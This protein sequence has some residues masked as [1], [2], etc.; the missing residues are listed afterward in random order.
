MAAMEEIMEFKR[1]HELAG[2]QPVEE[3]IPGLLDE[4]LVLLV[5]PEGS[6]KTFMAIHMGVHIA[7]GNKWKGQR[8]E[9]GGV[10]YC[11]AE[12]VSFFPYR[13]TTAIDHI[14]RDA[15]AAPFYVYS[16][17]MNLRTDDKGKLSPDVEKLCDSI[18]ALEGKE[19]FRMKLIVFDTLNRFMP[20]GDENNQEECGGLV[21]GCEYLK[22]QLGATIMLVHHTRKD[23]RAVRGNTVL[24]GAADQI[25]I[26]N[27]PEKKLTDEPVL[28]TTKE[29]GKRKDR[30]PIEQWFQFK[31]T[32]MSRG[33][34][35]WTDEYRDSL[36][37]D[38]HDQVV[39][40]QEFKD[41]GEAGCEYVDT[42]VVEETLVV[43][44]CEDPGPE[45][46]KDKWLVDLLKETGP[47][48]VSII[49]RKSGKSQKTCYAAL[50]RLVEAGSIYKDPE[51]KR[52]ASLIDPFEV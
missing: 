43:E 20:G 11:I 44:P 40:V 1:I 36:G 3:R 29:F 9:K 41:Y 51:T 24:S 16:H 5:G 23:G 33:N 15:S 27:R 26:S 10:L 2:M 45:P 47:S 31:K 14:G 22:D 17:S 46:G 52:Y 6:G 8:V 7:T 28:W 38:I 21:H 35:W 25:L 13:V 32:A 37:L 49:I 48:G 18:A 50:D 30:D 42:D 19:G 34:L 12:G 39:C 4:G